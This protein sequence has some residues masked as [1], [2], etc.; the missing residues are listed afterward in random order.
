M[1]NKYQKTLENNPHIFKNNVT[2]TKKDLRLGH[3]K[4]QEGKKTEKTQRVIAEKKA[5]A[6]S[7]YV[8][9]G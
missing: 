4:P 6:P 1:R 3:Q 2:V 5:S 8:K 7:Y 9:T